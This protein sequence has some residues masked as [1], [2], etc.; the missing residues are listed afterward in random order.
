MRQTGTDARR[1]A[2][3][4]KRHNTLSAERKN[5]IVN[6]TIDFEGELES[7]LSPFVHT[8]EGG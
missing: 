7:S 4:V 8:D 1:P 5:N 2:D 3:G 6:D